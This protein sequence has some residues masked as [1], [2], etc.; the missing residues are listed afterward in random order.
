M[1]GTTK[2]CKACGAETKVA[3][4]ASFRGEDGPVAVTV[5]GMPALVCANGHKRF[6]YPEFVARLL[7]LAADPEKVAPQPPAVKRGLFKK[8]YHCNGCDAE[9]PAMPSGKSER[10]L[11][12]N[13][14]NAAAFKVAVQIGLNKCAGCGREQVLSNDEFS[15]SAMKAMAHGFRAAD[16]HVDR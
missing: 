12:V 13:L 7:D 1:T 9:L 4:L 3:T 5:D 15:E 2:P 16:I 8:R 6:L 14:K 10:E 11:D